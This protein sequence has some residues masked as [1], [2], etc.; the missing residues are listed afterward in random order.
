MSR[1]I[2]ILK[3]FSD[4]EGALWVLKYYPGPGTRSD[5]VNTILQNGFLVTDKSRFDVLQ[6]LDEWGFLDTKRK[7]LTPKGEE[8]YNL[9]EMK[10]DV[11]LD[12]LHG[13]QY[14]LWRQHNPTQ[15]LSSWAY[16][17]VCD[18]LFD[19]PQFP[20]EQ[21][22]ISHIYGVR[23]EL[24]EHDWDIANAFS[25][26]SVRGAYDWLLPLKPSVFGGV[27]E[28]GR[29]NFKNATFIRRAYCAPALFLMGLTWV[30]REAKHQFGDLVAVDTERREKICRFCLIEENQFDFMFSETLRRFSFVSVH[31]TG[32]LY[33]AIAR[34]PTFSDF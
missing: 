15:H 33:I 6:L 13:L 28:T 34:E 1:R 3:G 32:K 5:I 19:S 24:N 21:D 4:L 14:G 16:R 23:E 11:A 25:K 2:H 7:S 22:V 18:Y 17:H 29:S 30:A 26:K 10:R 8:F 12:V 20:K 31:R 27:S 9:W